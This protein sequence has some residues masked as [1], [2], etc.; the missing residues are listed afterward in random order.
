[1]LLTTTALTIQTRHRSILRHCALIIVS[2]AAVQHFI[3]LSL[4]IAGTAALALESIPF[5]AARA[6]D[7][8]VA[9][10]TAKD[11]GVMSI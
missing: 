11:L 3:R 8:K 7:S 1:M 9:Q 4:S 2:L 10:G 5:G 6:D